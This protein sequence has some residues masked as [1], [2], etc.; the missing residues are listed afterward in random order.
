MNCGSVT[1]GDFP[2]IPGST[3]NAYLC[4]ALLYLTEYTLNAYE[5]G[6]CLVFAKQ[7]QMPDAQQH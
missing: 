2:P 6:N 3:L 1:G 5:F 7:L 4:V